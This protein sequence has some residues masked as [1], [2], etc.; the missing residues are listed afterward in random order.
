MKK[1]VLA[2]MVATTFGMADF[3]GGEINLGYYSHTPTG[4]AQNKDDIVDIKDDLNWKNEND[5]FFKAYIEHPLP[6][7]PNIKIGY[8]GFK[9]EGSGTVTDTFS[10]GGIQLFSLSDDVYSKLDLNFYDITL[11]YELLDNWLNLDMGLN[12]KYFDG[13]IDIETTKKHEHN[14]IQLPLPMLYLKARLD[15]PTTNLSFQAEGD[16]ISYEENNIYDLEIGARYEIVV[17]FGIEV[18]YKSLKIKIDNV[19]DFS[20]DA[21]F[22]GVYGKL[23]WDL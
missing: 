12:I 4:T 16:Y 3:I 11:Y 6:M 19:E 21:N 1:I 23:V 17:G 10:W 5:I 18:G 14:D 20:M 8:T 7:I 2:T 9:Q 13:A 15:I 22:N